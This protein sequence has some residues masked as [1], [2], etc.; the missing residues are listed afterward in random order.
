MAPR[1]AAG[2]GTFRL[3]KAIESGDTEDVRGLLDED[4]ALAGARNKDGA[5]ALLLSTYY[6]RKPIADLLLERGATPDI[7]DASALGLRDRVE[8]ILRSGRALVRAYSHDGWTPLHLA[9]HFGRLDVMKAILANGGSHR[10]I[11]KNANANQPLQAAA[12]GHQ[13]AAVELLIK[14]GADVNARSHS[15]FT[16]LH[17]AAANGIPEMVTMLLRAG[18]NVGDATDGGK[19]ALDYAMEAGHD[20]VVNLLEGGKTRTPRAKGPKAARLRENRAAPSR[21]RPRSHSADR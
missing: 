8:A 3:F 5:S 17:L 1:I 14:A 12:A 19:T 13:T 4:P 16:A 18:A 11:S 10:A 6:R 9:A 15:G 7:F 20:A 2:S 21:S